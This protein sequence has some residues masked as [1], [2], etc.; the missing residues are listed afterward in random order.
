MIS[1]RSLLV[2][3]VLA[4]LAGGGAQ[5]AQVQVDVTAQDTIVGN[6]FSF[7]IITFANLSDAGYLVS[8]AAITNG[9]ID[10]VGGAG[11][12]L[13]PSGGSATAT[14]GTQ[15]IPSGDPNDGC[16]PVQF[17]LTGFNPGNSFSFGAD[18]ESDACGSM[19]YDWRQRL[20][21]DAV[22]ANVLVEGPGIAGSLSLSGTDWVKELIDPQ[23]AD[24]SYNQRYR[25]TLTATIA[26]TP[27]ATPE[28]A[29][30]AILA[31]GLTGLGLARR[32]R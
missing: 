8:A 7:P 29:A 5:A 9:F 10:W 23:G 6:G 31:L 21:P 15:L 13:P 17:S 20:D 4:F 24:V 32:R 26:E 19:V 16:T 18:P 12:F 11:T 1:A 14:G 25:M 30:L 27:V 22:G 28:P 3:A 2:P